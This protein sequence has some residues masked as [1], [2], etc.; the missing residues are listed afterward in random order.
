MECP[1]LAVHTPREKK[2]KV[3]RHDSN[4]HLSGAPK[5][6]HHWCTTRQRLALTKQ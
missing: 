4:K 6:A 1:K 3:T 5:L 2:K